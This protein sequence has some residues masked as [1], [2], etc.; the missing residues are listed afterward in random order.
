MIG[1]GITGR[2]AGPKQPGPP[3]T[4]P[5]GITVHPIDITP[6]AHL[7]LAE[8][9]IEPGH[10]YGIHAHLTLEQIT[11][12]LSGRIRAITYDPDRGEPREIVAAT[13]DSVVTLPGESLQFAA[14][15]AT[16]ARVL[17]V[18]S[19]PYSTDHSDTV[20][21]DAH[22]PLNEAERARLLERRDTVLSEFRQGIG[23]PLPGT[24][25]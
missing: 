18:T 5:D 15:D 7:A 19:P 4:A 14:E 2:F 24:Q 25:P 8:G 6:C 3:I 1:H 20:T 21:L 9:D 23:R 16:P 13:G 17:F 12:V 10:T 11:Y 22:R